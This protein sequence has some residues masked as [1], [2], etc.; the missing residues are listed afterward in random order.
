MAGLGELFATFAK[1]G[2]FTFGGG[3]AMI[4]MIEHECVERRAWIEHDDM[5]NVTLM[6]ESTP[7]PIAINCATFVGQRQAGLPG[8]AVATLG[9][10]V[11]SFAIIFA[12]SMFLDDFMKFEVVANAFSGIKI[13][14]GILIVD[15]AVTMIQKMKKKAFPLAVVLCAC[16][17][18]LLSNALE[19]H[20]PSVALLLVAAAVGIVLFAVRSAG[21]GSGESQPREEGAR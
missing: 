15:A 13:A 14:V 17:V 1:I 9:M 6:A 21:K 5:V 8:A 12:I 10:V 7:G 20:I 2:L 18:M 16:S 3:Y 11:P 19:L 4:S